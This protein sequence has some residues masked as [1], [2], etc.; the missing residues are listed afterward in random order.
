M[1][2]LSPP[3]AGSPPTPHPRPE[4]GG[5]WAK[6]LGEA[7]SSEEATE[8]AIRMYREESRFS[9]TILAPSPALPSQCALGRQASPNQ[10]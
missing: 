6:G 5:N 4:W 3:V 2:F 8:V 7:S 1:G 10:P 9:P